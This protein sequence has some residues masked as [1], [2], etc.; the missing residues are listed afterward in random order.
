MSEVEATG[1]D[2]SLKTPTFG[3]FL[4]DEQLTDPILLETND[5][6]RLGKRVCLRF[7]AAGTVSLGE[8]VTYDGFMTQEDDDDD[9]EKTQDIAL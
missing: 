3:T 1:K 9:N 7:E 5:E 4:N 6:I 2:G 8:D